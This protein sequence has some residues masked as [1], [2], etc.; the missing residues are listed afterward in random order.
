MG[1]TNE[2]CAI[3]HVLQQEI[4]YK[5]L[6]K[7]NKEKQRLV[8]FYSLNTLKQRLCVLISVAYQS[9]RLHAS[10][11][12]QELRNCGFFIPDLQSH[13]LCLQKL[14]V[15]YLSLLRQRFQEGNVLR[16]HVLCE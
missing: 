2:K 1:S 3:K 7:M 10:F 13:Y 14:L 6:E 4:T 12:Q 15:M 16:V 8:V 9:L 5:T 11:A